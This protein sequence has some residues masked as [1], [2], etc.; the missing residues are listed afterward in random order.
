[1]P[2]LHALLIWVWVLSYAL[3][4]S[5]AGA[6]TA[7]TFADGSI[8]S[9]MFAGYAT[10]GDIDGDGDLDVISS[11]ADDPNGSLQWYENLAG[12]GSEWMERPIMP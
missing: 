3:A 12:N 7:V 8:I 10:V 6:E 9:P 1:M 2:L 5:P 4:V 11:P